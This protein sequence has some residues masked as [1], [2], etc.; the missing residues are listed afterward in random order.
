MLLPKRYRCAAENKVQ[1]VLVYISSANLPYTDEGSYP[2]TVSV[3][4]DGGATTTLTGTA[5]VADAPLAAAGN[6][7]LLSTNPVNNLL[8]ATF[9]DANPGGAGRGLHRHHRL[10]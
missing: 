4:D 10:G 8:V 9:T 1:Q 3:I 7:N 2:L 5:T 6:P